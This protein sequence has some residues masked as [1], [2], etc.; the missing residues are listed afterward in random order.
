MC[1]LYSDSK[2]NCYYH[3]GSN[4]SALNPVSSDTVYDIDL[5]SLDD[6]DIY[7]AYISSNKIY[8]KN[9]I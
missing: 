7:I 1:C 9:S 5:Y 4:W 8:V 2:L 3:D 6:S